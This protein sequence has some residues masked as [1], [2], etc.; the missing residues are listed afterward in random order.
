MLMRPNDLGSSGYRA[1]FDLMRI[2][3]TCRGLFERWH[4]SGQPQR[5]DCG[6][7]RKEEPAWPGF[8]FNERAHLCECCAMTVLSSGSR[9]SVWFC[10]TCRKR[11]MGFNARHGYAVIPIGRHSLMA[12]VTVSGSEFLITMGHDWEGE[13]PLDGFLSATSGL[14]ARM[15]HLHAWHEGVV[16]GN[17]RRLGLDGLESVALDAYLSAVIADKSLTKEVAFEALTG[18]FS[19]S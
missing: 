3:R 6:S 2:C 18:H 8:D 12:G 10:Q 9:W 13:G 19:A 15:D 16:A 14:I 7:G 4:P 11:V 17:L 1:E 5:C